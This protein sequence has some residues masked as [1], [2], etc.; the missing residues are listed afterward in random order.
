MVV[1]SA[2]KQYMKLP[3]KPGRPK[4]W[5]PPPGHEKMMDGL[6]RSLSVPKEE[7]ERREKEWQAERSK[8][9]EP[10]GVGSD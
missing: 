2:R 5:T 8:P 1:L 6:R 9:E 10:P 4:K 7:I 3:K